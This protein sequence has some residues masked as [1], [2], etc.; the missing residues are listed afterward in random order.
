MRGVWAR[1]RSFWQGLRKPAQVDAD[2]SDEMQFHLEMETQRLMSRGLDAD[3]A[4]RHAALAFGGIEKY[5][6]AGRDALGFSW[7]RGLSVDLKLG[8]RMLSRYPGLT[9]VAVFALSLAIGAGAAYL[10]FVNDLLHGKLPFPDADRIVGIQNWDQQ[11]GD[12]EHRSTFDFVIWRGQLA[13]FEE[14]GAYRA[15]DRNL[16][17]EDGRAEPVRGAEIS[18]SAFR[19]AAVPPLLGRPLV[20]DDERPGAAPAVLISHDVWVNRFASDPAVVGRTVRVGNAPHT[21]VG[22]MPAEF[23]FP[24]SHNL[25][26]PLSLRAPE[27][28]RRAGPQT[29]VFGK[30]AAGVEIAAAQAE[31][32]A[33]ARRMASEFPDTH[34]HLNPVVKEFVATVW[35]SADTTM[36]QRAVFYGANLFFV[37]LL[38][39]CGANIATLVFARTA[40]RDV[41][42]SVRTALGASR[43]RIAGQLFAEALVLAALAAIVGLTVAVYS[44]GWV[45]DTV[46]V[47]QGNRMMFWWDDEL[48]WLSI[49]YAAVLALVSA[50]IV[51]VIPALKATG[52]RVHERL[53]QATGGSSAG[54]KFGGVWTGVIVS[55]V[56]VTVVFLA[57]VATLGWGLYFANAGDAQVNYP[58][59]EYVGV[60]VTIDREAPQGV[61]DAELDDDGFR[62]RTRLLQTR[63]MDRL[64]AEPRVTAV[65]YAAH[66]PNSTLGEM[67]VEVDGIALDTPG[68]RYVQTSG[69]AINFLETFR[70]RLISGRGFTESDLAPGRQV[71]IVDRTFVGLLANGRDPVGGRIR[72]PPRDGDAAGPWIEVVGVVDALT[73]EANRQIYDAVVYRPVA[74]DAMNPIRIAAHVNGDPAPMLWRLR[75]IAAEVDASLRLDTPVTLNNVGAADRVAIEFFLR[76]LAGIGI[77]ALVLATAG[78]YALMSFTVARRTTEIGI[79]LALGADPRRIVVTTFGGA[80]AQIG[81]GVLIGSLPAAALVASLAPEVSSGANG[82]TAAVVICGLAALFMVGVTTLACVPPARRALRIQPIDT[83][84]TT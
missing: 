76:L 57:I 47:A 72:I 78:M 66:F 32:T 37:G 81:A 67:R 20:E 56:G 22:V 59:S 53:R 24:I 19:I 60:R 35:S 26:V 5:R 58:A 39:L 27:Y 40:T 41:E 17:T 64:A 3:E 9:A 1:V 77:V 54:L 34:Q 38:A 79:R 23:G 82:N 44:L 43:A 10:E 36:L 52:P 55:Q 49:I 6:G 16:I 28:P 29:R 80:L 62:A 42:I 83:L 69:V 65:T 8:V 21:I 50:A 74:A 46:T 31:L 70:A 84:K 12:P 45:K 7:A 11:T 2:M 51:G 73:T 33:V 15:L 71:A 25:W 4:R 13:S 61:S 68:G 14:L 48:S 30:L 75:V 63:F 18:A